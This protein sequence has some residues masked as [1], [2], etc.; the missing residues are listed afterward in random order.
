MGMFSRFLLMGASQGGA[1][2]AKWVNNLDNPDKIDKKD[3]KKFVKEI[4]TKD[5]KIYDA[6][7][8]VGLT[9]AYNLGMEPTIYPETFKDYNEYKK[10]HDKKYS[11]RNYKGYKKTQKKIANMTDP[12][13]ETETE[14]KD[15]E[16]EEG[17]FEN[18]IK[19]YEDNYEENETF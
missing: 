15:D 12:E 2:L 11:V 10:F 4:K 1:S 6:F 19:Y 17:Y 5:E 13:E 18:L 14:Y 3:Y 7:G 8:Y 16:F 9:V